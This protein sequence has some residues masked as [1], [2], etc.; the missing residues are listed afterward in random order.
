MTG[1]RRFRFPRWQA[2]LGVLVALALVVAYTWAFR[3][4]FTS[5]VPGAND[6]FSRWAGARLYLTRG[7]D[8]YGEQTSLWI[9]N[10]IWGHPAGPDEDPSLFAY[11][12]YTVFLVAPY[13]LLADYSWAQAA[14]QVTLQ[15][16][17]LAAL[18]LTLAYH[19]WRP[20]LLLLGALLFWMIGFYPTAR[21]IILGQIGLLVFALTVWAL[22]L[23]VRPDATAPSPVRDR[24]AGVLLA[25]T[26]VKP[27]MQFLIIPF[28]LLWALRQRRW[29]VV[30]G[31]GLALAALLALSFALLPDW[32]GEWLAQ[33]RLYPSY[34]PPAVLYILTREVLPLGAASGSVERGLD[35][36]LVLYLL[37]EWWGV[38]SARDAQEN[39]ARLAWVVGLTLVVTHLVAPRTATTHFVVFVFPL[40]AVLRDLSRHKPWGGWA[41]FALVLILTAGMWWLFLATL[42]G[43]QEHNLVHVPLPLLVLLLLLLTRPR[44]DP[45]G[46]PVEPSAS[47]A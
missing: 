35:V 44:D 37:V 22:W 31:F 45:G 41:A 13:A 42:E 8:P 39:E 27:Q 33:V 43:A 30:V 1:S 23:V 18:I 16:V 6:F 26:T 38:L 11:P 21:S 28:I 2:N 10:A 24:L 20:R 34:T 7:W 12:F 9:Q 15:G 47:P 36:I 32:V 19:R 29:Q 25:L 17:A 4:Q 46:H 3:E 40:V 14:W 5:Q